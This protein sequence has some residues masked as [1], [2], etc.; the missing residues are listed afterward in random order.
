VEFEPVAEGAIAPNLYFNIPDT[1]GKTYAT[2][3]SAD[4]LP[5]GVGFKNVSVENMDSVAVQVTLYDSLNNAVVYPIQKLRTLAAGDTMHINLNLNV[6]GLNG[7]YNVYVKINPDNNQP[8]QY[9]FNSFLYKYVYINQ[10]AI[11][12][13]S[14]L[15]FNAVLVGSNVQTSW[16]VAA[17]SN[18]KQYIVQHSTNGS[19]F[20]PIGKRLALNAGS[21]NASYNFEHVNAPPGK[22]FYRLQIIDNDGTFKL[23]PVR[24]VTIGT[25]NVVN[26]YPNPVKDKVNVSITRQDGK[27]SAVRLLT[28]FGQE[29]WQQ[30]VSGTVQIDMTKLAA[31]VYLLQVD[32]GNTLKTYKINKQ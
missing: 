2:T 21:G 10:A 20:V 32:D 12:P 14:L 8:E 19:V 26:V 31:G 28:Q 27:P 18:A 16:V 11:L 13:V 25:G 5:I 24:L 9:S 1:I 22:N 4:T 17:E 6:S 30:K 7:L 23:S 3:T 15:D 29:L